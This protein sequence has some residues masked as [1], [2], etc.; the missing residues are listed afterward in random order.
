MGFMCFFVFLKKNGSTVYLVIRKDGEENHPGSRRFINGVL[1]TTGDYCLM[2][3]FTIPSRKI[4]P[5]TTGD[6]T[7]MVDGNSQFM[8]YDNPQ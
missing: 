4:V 1:V 3:S 2:E 7:I 8:G 6:I 5:I